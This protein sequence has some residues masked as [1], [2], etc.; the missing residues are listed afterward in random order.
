MSRRTLLVCLLL[1][2]GTAQ[3]APHAPIVSPL[4]PFETQAV[5][6]VD[7]A[8]AGDPE[9][10][11][12]LAIVASGDRARAARFDADRDR[13]QTLMGALQPALKAVAPRRAGQLLFEVVRVKL[14]ADGGALTGYDPSQSSVT[15]L[16]DTGRFNCDSAALLY[17]IL[18]RYAGL[19]ARAVVLP[20]HTFVRLMLPQGVVDVEPT[21]PTGYNVAHD[22]AWLTAAPAFMTPRG[23]TAPTAAELSAASE[24]DPARAVAHNMLLQHTGTLAPAD[25]QRLAEI[26]WV[27]DPGNRDLA[28]ARLQNLAAESAALLEKSPAD[29]AALLTRVE[30]TLVALRDQFGTDPDFALPFGHIDLWRAEV[31]LRRGRDAEG[32]GTLARAFELY[33]SRAS[34]PAGA[35][36]RTAYGKAILG[37]LTRVGKA[38][39][40]AGDPPG[41]ARLVERFADRLKKTADGHRWAR[42]VYTEWLRDRYGAQ[43]WATALRV[44]QLLGTWTTAKENVEVGRR[45]AGLHRMLAVGAQKAGDHAAAVHH[46][47]AAV[48]SSDLPQERRASRVTE[49]VVLLHVAD[50]EM[51]SGRYEQAARYVDTAVLSAPDEAMRERARELATVVY[52]NWANDRTRAKAYNKAAEL[53]GKAIARAGTGDRRANLLQ[54]VE[55]AYLAWAGDRMRS[56]DSEGARRILTQ[57]SQFAPTGKCADEL[58]IIS[59]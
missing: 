22:P 19:P 54:N 55:V 29:A 6:R 44:N 36:E 35:E 47:Q 32:L 49:A 18:A 1:A 42:W 12:A 25:R 15:A 24:L 37:T 33:D 43:D 20:S 8:R 30:S 31:N 50:S 56:A 14:L 16:L 21:S 4:T 11:L 10:L 52:G 27:L 46:A 45:A 13:L 58:K 59:P 17:L 23:L 38:R 28:K 2:A 34:E 40:K 26:A 9:A 41:A 53:F 7:R 5:A 57:C 51:K 48:K 39:V 3:A